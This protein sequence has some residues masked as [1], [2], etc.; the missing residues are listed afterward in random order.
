MYVKVTEDLRAASLRLGK[1]E[2]KLNMFALIPHCKI[3]KDRFKDKPHV[4]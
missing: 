4:D 1:A 2:I 3:L